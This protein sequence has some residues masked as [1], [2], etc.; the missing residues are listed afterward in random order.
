[1]NII[2]L[3]FYLVSDNPKLDA[4]IPTKISSSTSQRHPK[5]AL[6]NIQNL[7]FQRNRIHSC[8][9]LPKRKGKNHKSTLLYFILSHNLIIN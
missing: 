5:T 9:R 8:H 1:M 7:R 4:Q 3:F 6:L 2:V